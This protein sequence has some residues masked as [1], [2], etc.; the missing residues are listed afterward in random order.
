MVE[1]KEPFEE[2]QLLLEKL[3]KHTNTCSGDKCSQFSQLKA[4]QNLFITIA[5][6]FVTILI[7]ISTWAHVE[8][9]SFKEHIHIT[10]INLA[11]EGADLSR[12][13]QGLSSDVNKICTAIENNNCRLNSIKLDVERLKVK[14]P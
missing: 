4:K 8:L 10:E 13:V 3:I 11:S 12:Q 2:V 7:G 5:G 6:V 1:N 14:V 9:S